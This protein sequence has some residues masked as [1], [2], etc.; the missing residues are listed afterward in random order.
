M[1]IFFSFLQLVVF[2]CNY[3]FNCLYLEDLVGKNII[4]LKRNILR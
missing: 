3:M 4:Y 2:R 1:E